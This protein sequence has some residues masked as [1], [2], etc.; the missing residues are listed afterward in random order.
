MYG[1][2]SGVFACVPHECSALGARRGQ[3]PWEWSYREMIVSHI[4]CWELNQGPLEEQPVSDL[5]L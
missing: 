1:Y 2:F 5:N 3:V 4:G